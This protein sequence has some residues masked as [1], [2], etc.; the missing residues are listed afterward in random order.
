MN[1]LELFS[2]IGGFSLGLHQAGFTFDKVYF[3]EIDRHAIAN[4]KHNFPNAQHVGSV[5]DITRASIER[6]DIITFGSPCQNFSASGNGLGLQGA[7]SSLIRYAIEAIDYFRPDIFIWENVKGVLFERHC[8]DFWAIVK[9]FA[10]IGL[11]QIEWQLLNTAWVLPQN[12]ERIYLVGR[13]AEKCRD[14]VFPVC[15]SVFSPEKESGNN[16]ESKDCCGT[17]IKT[18]GRTANWVTYVLQLQR[19]EQFDGKLRAIHEGQLR[20]LTETECER[21]QGFP[22]GFTRYGVYDG[23]VREISRTQRYSLLG[24]AVSPPIV[25]KVAARIRQ[26]T[27]LDNH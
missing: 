17:L 10:D 21:L 4:F 2:G 12:R 19:G 18:Y 23:E 16:R 24:N 8:R 7:E 13:L 6:P 3:S 25:E 11:Y 1:L 22:D 27:N 15:E 9:A 14:K 20:L 5:C 26:T